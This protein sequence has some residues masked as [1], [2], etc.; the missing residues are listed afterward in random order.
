MSDMKKLSAAGAI[1]I[2]LIPLIVVSV[3]LLGA[4][5]FGYWAFND[6]QDYKY[7]SDQKVAAAVDAAQKRTAA[8]D[9]KTFAEQE[10]NPLKKYVGPAAFG[11]VTV[12]YPKTWS[13][14][15]QEN[16]SAQPL[17][18]YFQPDFVP[19]AAGTGQVFA[20]RIQLVQQS[21]DQSLQQYTSQVESGGLTITPYS[22]P[23]VTSV[24]GARIT[25][26]I[27]QNKNGE[28]IIMPLRN[29]TL[30]ISTESTNYLPDFRNIIL[31]N[32]VFTP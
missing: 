3:F 14:Y 28:M 8:A 5:F 20:L 11:S 6:R 18:G 17:N 19:D 15:V 30:K 16:S 26:K 12:Q 4:A 25:G 24:I 7:N 2:L 32:L 23:K 10:K 29:M 9:A 27:E 22:F 1:N 13:A 21:Y 31:P